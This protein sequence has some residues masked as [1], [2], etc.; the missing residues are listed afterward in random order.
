MS[1]RAM[2]LGHQIGVLF[3]IVLMSFVFYNDLTRIFGS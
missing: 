3:L 1:E 2:A